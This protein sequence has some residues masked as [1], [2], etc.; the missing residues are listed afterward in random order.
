MLGSLRDCNA[1]K[2]KNVLYR[3]FIGLRNKEA[4]D[5]YKKYENK[6][7]HTIRVSKK[8]YYRKVLEENK[9]NI[10]GIWGTLNSIFGNNHQ[11]SSYLVLH[12]RGH[13]YW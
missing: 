8:D 6:F 9:N 11:Q 13:D 5:R 10:K 12:W 1:C 7:T 3:E 2:N 4:D